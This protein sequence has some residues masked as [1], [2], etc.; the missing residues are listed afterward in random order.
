LPSTTPFAIR[1]LLRRCLQKDAKKRLRD[2]GD[3]RIEIEE[4]LSGAAVAEPVAVQR[5]PPF[6]WMGTAAVLLFA[7]GALSFVHFREPA[8]ATAA[9]VVFQIAAPDK[10]V[11]NGLSV[12][13]DGQHVAF[14]A[15]DLDGRTRLW[16]RSLGVPEARALGV[17]S[18]PDSAFWSPDSRFIGFAT[19]GN[20][21]L[22]KVEVVGGPAETICSLSGRALRGATWNAAGDILF[23][24]TGFYGTGAPAL[25]RV[26]AA[27]GTPVPVTLVDRAESYEIEPS[28]LPD[29]RHFLYLQTGPA[30]E[31]SGIFVGSLDAKPEQQGSRRLL[32]AGGAA[33]VPPA[34][35]ENSGMGRLLFERDGTLM[36]QPFDPGRLELQGEAY[37]VA[38]EVS[39]G[40]IARWSVSL[41]GVLAFQ[42]VHAE[43]ATTHL[44]WRDRQGKAVGEMGPPSNYGLLQLSFDGKRIVVTKGDQQA[45]GGLH[46]WVA[47]VARSVFTRVNVSGG[48]ENSPAI[49]V[50]GRVAFSSTA[51][52]AAGDI[53]A[54]QVNGVGMPELWVKSDARPGIVQH[55]NGFSADGRF[56]IYDVHD[57]Q[58][59]QDL[60][61]VS[62]TGEHKPIP[63]LT[64]SA[65]ETYGQFS[66]DEKWIAYDSDESGRR[67]VYVQGFAPDRSP[68]AAVGKWQISSAGGNKPRWS[69]NGRELFYLSLDGKLM[70]VP[71]KLGTTFEPGVPVPLFEV[72]AN[73]FFPYDVS[74]DGRFLINT[75]LESEAPAAAMTVVVNWTAGLKK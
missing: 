62:T 13:P 33:Y 24:A 5:Q 48:N 2:A 67:E 66:P 63:F 35:G 64:T 26:P 38:R 31:R 19:P 57:P 8:P 22:A 42:V 37:P 7:L 71:I 53:Y 9:P 41:A 75:P 39:G 30:A 68:A 65:D 20:I 61:V 56:L 74:P 58:R 23:S 10:T 72:R 47:D 59:R 16:V 40:D 1:N 50:D 44:V 69:H 60:W 28:F 32:A 73:G 17:L 15:R 54:S 70:A 36:A 21:D 52:G 34:I 29:G 51:N 6:G 18:A 43:V 12:S 45:A 14:T 3:A 4:V 55:P 49:S 11:I 25:R 27:G 46:S